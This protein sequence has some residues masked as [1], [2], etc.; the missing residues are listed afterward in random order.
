M[1]VQLCNC[2][3]C[4]VLSAICATLLWPQLGR[5]SFLGAG[6]L[7]GTISQSR[8]EESEKKV[9][10][11]EAAKKEQ[12]DIKLNAERQRNIAAELKA[13]ED[14]SKPTPKK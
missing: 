5:Y 14:L 9:R 10:V 7:Y 12:R 6:I 13:L 3:L 1:C 11:I 4:L 2:L 8:L